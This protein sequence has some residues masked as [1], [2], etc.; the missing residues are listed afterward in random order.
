MLQ[1]IFLQK[2]RFFAKI[3]NGIYSLTVSVKSSIIRGLYEKLLVNNRT[4]VKRLIM[5][6]AD[7]KK[8]IQ[9][10]LVQVTLTCSK[11]II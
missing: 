7:K 9:L 10:K 1:K 5:I 11:S 4:K 2:K 6:V 3:V 8:Y